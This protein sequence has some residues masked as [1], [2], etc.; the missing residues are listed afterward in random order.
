MNHFYLLQHLVNRP[1]GV[2][3]FGNA[4]FKCYRAAAYIGKNHDKNQWECQAKNH[5]RRAA[6]NG[7]ET[8]YGYGHGS[9]EI[10]VFVHWVISHWVI[11]SL[12]CCS[13]CKLLLHTAN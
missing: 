1:G 12:G 8:G 13:D 7:A 6:Y 3:R 11:V 10:A 4:N 9:A 2:A 5:R